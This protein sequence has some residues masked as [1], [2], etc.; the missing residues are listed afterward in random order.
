MR[1]VVRDS[2]ELAVFEPADKELWNQQYQKYLAV[3]TEM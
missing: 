1:K 2:S 3:F